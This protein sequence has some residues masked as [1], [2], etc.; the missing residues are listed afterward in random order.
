MCCDWD[1]EGALGHFERAIELDP[2]Y[3]YAHYQYAWCLTAMGRQV[4]AVESAR[5]AAEAEPLSLHIQ[6]YVAEILAMCGH[7]DAAV[8]Q[9]RNTL[10]LDADF[11]PAIEALGHAYTYSKRYDEAVSTLRRVPASPRVSQALRLALLYARVG[12]VELARRTLEEEE[13]RLADGLVPAGNA[14]FYLAAGALGVGDVERCLSWLERLVEERRFLGCLLKVDPNWEEI[15]SHP[16]FVELL[17]RLR[18]E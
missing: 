17:R 8:E 10:E 4:E 2:T 13:A 1:W 3:A 15:R 14:G 12:E 16:R 11:V 9:A 18:L 5:R 6:A 7:I